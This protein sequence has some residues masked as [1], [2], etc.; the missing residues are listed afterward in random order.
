MQRI[1]RARGGE[2]TIVNSN[3]NS[4]F[5]SICKVVQVGFP[6]VEFGLAVVLKARISERTARDYMK[7]GSNSERVT[8]FGETSV[9]KALELLTE[10]KA[11]ETQPA[12]ELETA[13]EHGLK[14]ILESRIPQLWN[15]LQG[16]L[17]WN[18]G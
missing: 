3:R 2:F 4:Y 15:R 13:K 7:L 11:A 6:I 10:D 1:P 8:N 12:L 5:A 9:R 16:L 18:M 14:R 17:R